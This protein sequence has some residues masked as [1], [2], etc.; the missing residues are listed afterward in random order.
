MVNR[1][2]PH[3]LYGN[4]IFILL[5]SIAPMIAWSQLVRNGN[6]ESSTP[7]IV[8]GSAVPGWQIFISGGNA[9]FEIVNDS[10]YSG[11]RALKV[12][13]GAIGANQW[14][15]QI[16]A[17][18]IPIIPG[19]RYRYSIW[20][21]AQRVG[22]QVNFTVGKYNY[23]EYGAIRP[24][25]LTTMWKEYVLEFTV[26]D[27][28]QWARAPIHFNYSGNVNNAIYI[29]KLKIVDLDNLRNPII[30]EAENGILGSAF[31]KG[32]EGVVTYITNVQNQGGDFPADTSRIA[33]YQVTFPDSGTYNLFAR[34]KVGPNTYNDDSFF[35]GNGFGVK[36]LN[37]ESW[38]KVNGLAAAGYTDS[39]DIVKDIGGAGSNV[40]KWVRLSTIQNNAQ[41]WEEGPLFVVSSDDSLTQVIQIGG[42]EDGL[43]IDKIA[44][45]RVEYFYRVHNLNNG[46]AG[47]QELPP[48]PWS[49]PP[50]AFRQKKFVGNI[51]SVTQR[52]N[53]EAYWNQVTPENA[54]KWGSVE[55][56]RDQMNWT[57]LDSSYALAKRNNFPFVFHVLVWGQQQPSW[58][59]SLSDSEKIEEIREWFQ[60][61][62]QRYP[63]IEYLQVVN[64]PLHAPPDGNSGR[65]NYLSALGGTGSTGFDWI[66]TAFRMA[67]EIF[68]RTTKLM[69]NDYNIINDG[70]ATMN[71]LRI[72][73]RLQSENLIDVIGEQGHAFTT[74][75]NSVVM[76]RNLDSLGSTRLPIQITELDIDGP[77]DEEQLTS[78]KRIFPLFYSHPSV[79]GI[80]LWGW[81][82]GLWRNDQKAYIVLQNG[83][84][85]PAMQWL[86]TYL[87][88]ANVVLS[89][90]T[91]VASIPHEYKLY[92]NFPNPFNPETN[93]RYSVPACSYISLK[94]Y[95]VLGQE[96]ATLYEGIQAPGIHTAVFDGSNLPSGVYYCRLSGVNVSATIRMLLLK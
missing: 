33:T 17:D 82:P 94:V 30:V 56:I 28:E 69:I 12:N 68:P 48:P 58:I 43:Y 80:T 72:I 4:A 24:A 35:Y 93:I 65:A 6:F 39:L 55:P 38:I 79:Q 70:T 40:W 89:A 66:I 78:Y 44:F 54:G 83:E 1:H 59:S 92:N 2:V 3:R 18:S 73:R 29:D 45:G 49:G 7:G 20:A 67:R 86:R 87:D 81:R 46:T 22:A 34:V 15:I 23:V 27:Q 42:R 8:T 60:A 47:F 76:R 64:E 88:T 11:Q 14:D 32:T 26:G 13:V 77:T 96:I 51:Y 71:Y 84:E 90:E 41:S 53:F 16:V 52:P 5:F 85:R 25:N 37:A 62:A 95:N 36:A 75:A 50:L 9:Q 57:E 31:T 21:K 19:H 61:V 63:N 74:T 10:V 91:D